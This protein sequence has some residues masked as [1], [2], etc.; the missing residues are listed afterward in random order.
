MPPPSF[1]NVSSILSHSKAF[2]LTPLERYFIKNFNQ[3]SD[4]EKKR[5]LQEISFF[6]LAK[7]SHLDKNFEKECIRLNLEE[8]WKKQWCLLGRAISQQKNLPLISFYEHPTSNYFNLVRGACFFS[9][10]IE[11]QK[12]I[13]TDFSYL[14]LEYLKI[15]MQYGSIHA[16]QRYNAYLYLQLHEVPNNGSRYEQYITKVELYDTLVKNSLKMLP[17]YGTY[18]YMVIAEA[19]SRYALWML[20]ENEV[21]KAKKYYTEAIEAID[22]AEE[23]LDESVYSIHNASLGNGLKSSNSFEFDS[24]ERAKKML[25]DQFKKSMQ[26]T[27]PIGDET[28][29]R[30]PRG[31]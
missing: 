11:I 9:L 4:E 2:Q 15:A 21:T 25:I 16:T 12:E 27:P 8:T 17:E 1:F 19:L 18:G 6:S 24:P 3:L 5:K 30:F 22:Y 13:K 14:E 10:S 20:E 29:N 26:K 7:M 28:K 23:L 31:C